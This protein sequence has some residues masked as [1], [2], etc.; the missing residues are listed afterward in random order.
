MVLPVRIVMFVALDIFIG[1]VVIDV[2]STQPCIPLAKLL[3]DVLL[4][5]A[6]RGFSLFC[7][8]TPALCTHLLCHGSAGRPTCFTIFSTSFHDLFALTFHRRKQLDAY[9]LQSEVAGVGLYYIVGQSDVLEKRWLQ[10]SFRGAVQF[11]RMQS[12]CGKLN[13]QLG[14]LSDERTKLEQSIKE[15]EKESPTSGGEDRLSELSRASSATGERDK[16]KSGYTM[17]HL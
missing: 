13:K 8:W 11:H 17:I 10:S 7:V 12:K 6:L 16:V 9:S 3:L 14:D 15:I 1:F 5:C 4:L 2:S